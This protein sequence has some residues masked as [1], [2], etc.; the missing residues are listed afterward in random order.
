[1]L[2]GAADNT[3]RL[4]DTETG[5]EVSQFETSSA[6]RTCGFSSTDKL[7]MFTTDATIGK[8]CEISLFDVR[9]SQ[10]PVKK[11]SIEGSKVTAAVWG[12]ADEYIITGH[13]N[14][15]VSQYDVFKSDESLKTVR[16]HRELISDIQTSTDKTMVITAC[17]DT[18]AKLFDS[19]ELK[20]LKSYKAERPV[21]S[22]AMSPLRD[23]VVLGGGQE[24][25]E[26]TTTYTKAGKFDARF[27]HLVFEE[28]IGRV[29]GHFGPINSL[30]F[31]P[32]GKSYSS[33]G[34]D[35]YVRV[36]TFDPSYFDFDFDY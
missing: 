33:G 26:V 24:A 25:M 21:N 22:A 27:Y 35:G 31:H 17:K 14:G 10:A 3:A 29:K 32:D 18:S 7:L 9:E 4:W 36:H 6:V 20:V 5:R 8:L 11:L 16:E 12:P 19:D 1:M 34:E 15:T 30:A 13:E 28:E 2:T 23:H